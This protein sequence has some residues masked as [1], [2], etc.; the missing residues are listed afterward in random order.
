[1]LPFT[2]GGFLYIALVTVVPDL[3]KENNFVY[4]H[5]HSYFRN[6]AFTDF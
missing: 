2:A 4:E 1:M 3:M 6:I 5:L